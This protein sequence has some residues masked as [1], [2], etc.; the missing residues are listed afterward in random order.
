MEQ[1]QKNK[2][3]TQKRCKEK[4]ARDQDEEIQFHGPRQSQSAGRVHPDGKNNAPVLRVVE[5]LLPVNDETPNPEHHEKGNPLGGGGPEKDRK[6]DNKEEKN[7][8][9]GSWFVSCDIAR[10][11]NHFEN[12]EQNKE[13]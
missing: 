6:A 7:A 8:C 13:K 4:T 1:R 3:P 9:S 12:I 5:D 10:N 11:A 2:R